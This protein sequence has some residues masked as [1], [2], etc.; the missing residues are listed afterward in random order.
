MIRL[1]LSDFAPALSTATAV[2][3]YCEIN[4]TAMKKGFLAIIFRHNSSVAQGLGTRFVLALA[5]PL[6]YTILRISNI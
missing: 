4:V 3:Y 1:R 2:A 5:K 6:S